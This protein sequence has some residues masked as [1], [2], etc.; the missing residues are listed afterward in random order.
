[1]PLRNLRKNMKRQLWIKY[2]VIFLFL[3]SSFEVN[4]GVKEALR[5]AR[6]GIEKA[7]EIAPKVKKR[8]SFDSR[9]YYP[10]KIEIFYK[11]S[12]KRDST[13]EIHI[14]STGYSDVDKATIEVRLSRIDVVKSLEDAL[15]TAWGMVMKKGFIKSGKKTEKIET[16]IGDFMVEINVKFEG[17]EQAQIRF[18]K[19]KIKVNSLKDE[20]ENG[21]IQAIRRYRVSDESFI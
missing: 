13:E 20:F 6:E 4:C 12:V 8:K 14:K 10:G 19:I 3:F 21:T 2:L 9:N 1:M 7:V 5:F 11:V 15:L 16:R 17:S 18:A